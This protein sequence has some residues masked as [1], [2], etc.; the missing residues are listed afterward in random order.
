MNQYIA[1]DID[2]VARQEKYRETW[3]FECDCQLCIVDGGVSEEIRKERL[4]KFEELKE[5]VMKLGEKGPTTIT[6]LKKIAKRL[7]E[8]ETLYSPSAEQQDEDRYV[9]LPRLAL[10]HPT[11]F[12]TEAWRGVKNVDR[13]I[14]SAIKLLRNFGIIVKVE[15]QKL[16]VEHNSGLVNVETVRALK[17]L[18]EGYKTKGEEELAERCIAK[19]KK[20]YV[21]ITGSEVGM[22]RFFDS[23]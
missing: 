8:L 19:A 21:I 22:E 17:Y 13:M 5:T 11:L 15:G 20:W 6:A 1:P 16:N 12:L 18:A 14:E 4:A 23:E 3:S 9:T 2:I 7:R 10:V